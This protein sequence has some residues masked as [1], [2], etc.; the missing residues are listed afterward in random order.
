MENYEDEILEIVWVNY[1]ILVYRFMKFYI[2][3]IEFII[4]FKREVIIWLIVENLNCYFKVNN[5]VIF[6]RS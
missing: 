6:G 1:F 3:F 2:Y 4:F 5:F